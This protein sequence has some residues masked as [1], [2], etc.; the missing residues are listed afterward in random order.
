[1]YGVKMEESFVYGVKIEDT[2]Q[3]EETFYFTNDASVDL[4]IDTSSGVKK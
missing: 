3:K 2:S 1:M 4:N